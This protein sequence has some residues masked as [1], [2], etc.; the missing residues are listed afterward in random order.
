MKQEFENYLK[1]INVSEVMQEAVRKKYKMLCTAC[2]IEEF[3]EI[4]LSEII[5]KNGI[6]EYLEI[7]GFSNHIMCRSYIPKKMIV[8]YR[9][10]KYLRL[11]LLDEPNFELSAVTNDSNLHYSI[12]RIDSES[13]IDF[14]AT[15]INCKKLLL[16]SEKYFLP[17][18]TE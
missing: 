8:M 15:G 12:R 17:N 3:E 4:F 9:F 10:K 13:P 1:E 18:L 14:Y 2:N 16:V 5:S 11:V 6:R 7:W